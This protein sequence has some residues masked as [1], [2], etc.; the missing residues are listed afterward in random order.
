MFKYILLLLQILTIVKSQLTPTVRT[1][2]DTVLI[3]KKLYIF[4]GFHAPA[5]NSTIESEYNL[6][7]DDRFFYLDV[8]KPFDTS[9]LPWT[10]I[11]NNEK[12]LPLNFLSSIITGGVSASIGG[13]NNDTI[14]FINNERDKTL[15]PVLTFS[16]KDNLWH[17][18]FQQSILG[19]RPIGVTR[20]QGGIIV[21]DTINFSCVVKDA[22]ISRLEYSATL[23]P[24]GIIVYMGG[25]T[26]DGRA[27][28]DN[29]RIVYLYNTTDNTWKP[30]PTTGDIPA[31]DHGTSSVLGL[32][33]FRIIVFG[34]L[35]SG[36]KLLYV[37]DTRTFNWYEPNVSGK[38][39]TIKRFDHSANVIG[40]YMVIAFG[41]GSDLDFSYR[42]NSESD[43]LLLDIGNSSNYVWTNYFDPNAVIPPQ[44][45][46]LP[47]DSN[48]TQY[49]DNSN[50]NK[51]NNNN[52]INPGVIVGVVIGVIGI[53]C[54]ISLSIFYYVRRRKTGK[55]I[56]EKAIPT[57]SNSENIIPIPSDLE[58]TY[59]RK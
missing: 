58:L 41:S 3:D 23:L 33:G 10:P 31:G 57:P 54:I 25:K 56:Y 22:D 43:V 36:N 14:Y 5:P 42:S 52:N 38:N 39:P 8:S 35:N 55:G 1:L 51:K 26:S 27:D 28:T 9:S 16:T 21:F 46:S 34:G 18:I 24:N 49:N 37:L 7:P 6:N 20:N 59:G 15:P 30:Q 40:K 32:D 13:V 50:N 12:D 2:H 29:F 11:P 17:S 53:I 47:T 19:D 4:G 45:T 48:S 44:T